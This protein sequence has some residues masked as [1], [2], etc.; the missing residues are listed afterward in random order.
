[1]AI[2]VSRY[3]PTVELL[4]L[5]LLVAYYG[6]RM[7]GFV[8][9]CGRLNIDPSNCSMQESAIMVARLKYPQPRECSA[10]RLRQIAKRSNYLIARLEDRGQRN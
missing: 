7:N 10:E 9:A 3:V 8:Q 6:W 1:M 4:S 5:Y 2:L